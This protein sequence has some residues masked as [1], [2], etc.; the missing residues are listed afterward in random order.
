MK[1][2][3]RA[4]SRRSRR[5]RRAQSEHDFD[6]TLHLPRRVRGPD[7]PE[8]TAAAIRVRRAEVCLVQKVECL[9]AKLD[10]HAL[11]ERQREFLLEAEVQLVERVAANDIAAGVA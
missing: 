9:G 2:P 3:T 1:A 10:G 4:P 7:Q 8:G 5:R 6:G 11:A